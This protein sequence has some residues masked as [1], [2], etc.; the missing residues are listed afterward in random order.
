[1]PSER[2]REFSASCWG[3]DGVAGAASGGTSGPPAELLDWVRRYADA[4]SEGHLDE[5]LAGVRRAL[6]HSLAHPGRDREGAFSLL[7]ADGLLTLAVQRLADADDPETG[8]R[9][10]VAALAAD[11]AAEPSVTGEAS[12]R[13]D[14]ALTGGG[15]A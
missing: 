9:A 1:M 8:L 7:A 14:N 3:F 12:A 13:G 6:R 5:L 15:R 11:A 4:P 10:L 2:E